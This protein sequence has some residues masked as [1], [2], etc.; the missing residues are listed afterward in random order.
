MAKEV[1][2]L[3]QVAVHLEKRYGQT[4]AQAIMGKALKRYEELIEENKD[5][6]KEYYMHTRQRIYPSIAVFDAI[7]GEGIDR[8]EAADF[9]VT[10]YKW[11]S[12]KL[13]P[14][15][16]AIMKIPGLYK[17][18]PKFFYSMTRKSFGPQAGFASD[19]MHL[20]KN[21]MGF[22]MIKCPYNDN[23]V[24][25][26]CPEIVKGFCDAD[27]ICY[28]NIHPKLVWGRTKTLGHGG[29]VCDF[30]ISIKE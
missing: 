17:V 11:R 27:D 18:V 13:A 10:Y 7:I 20:R 8:G 2:Y 5:E 1:K 26:G 22:D 28:G 4:K 24:K 25:Y 12:S 30:R 29:D 15:I 3:K 9:V 6:P 16:K 21:D 14:K 23:C 19:N